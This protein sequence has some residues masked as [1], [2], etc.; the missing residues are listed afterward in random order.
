M[1]T[2]RPAPRASPTPT[3]TMIPVANS[4]SP[5]SHR[6]KPIHI[7]MARVLPMTASAIKGSV[8][9]DNMVR[10]AS[11]NTMYIYGTYC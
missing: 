3:S 9:G 8:E 5:L 2:P 11:D 7:P 4:T 6:T 10:I 1:S